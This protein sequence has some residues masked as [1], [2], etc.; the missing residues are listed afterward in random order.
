MNNHPLGETQKISNKTYG[1]GFIDSM[2]R[3][4]LPIHVQAKME[5]DPVSDDKV[6]IMNPQTRYNNYSST[7]TSLPET[8]TRKDSKSQYRTRPE[9]PK[10][11]MIDLNKN[12]GEGMQISKL[13]K[14][15]AIKRPEKLKFKKF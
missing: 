11:N 2:T 6:D 5:L 8:N 9:T 15:E 12:K 13:K 14:L 7:R 4:K 10:L 3:A 1:N